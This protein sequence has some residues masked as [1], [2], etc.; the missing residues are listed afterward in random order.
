MQDT[1]RNL[2]DRLETVG[3]GHVEL[4]DTDVSQNMSNAI[5]EGFTRRRQDYIVPD[6]FGMF[7]EK[8]NQAV[9]SAIAQYVADACQKADEIGLH[10]F[11]DRLRAVQNGSIR[12]FGGNYYDD[13]LGHTPPEFFDKNGNV[14][15]TR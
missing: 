10:G 6:D 7:S 12:S 13:F 9:K 1:P 8:T 15:R 2:L 11:H 4:F 3:G 14:I 5:V